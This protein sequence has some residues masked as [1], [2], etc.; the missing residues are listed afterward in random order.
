MLLIY[1]QGAHDRRP[2]AK[3]APSPPILGT[4]LAP[5][6][7]GRLWV[8]GKARRGTPGHVFS[9][10][11]AQ[12]RGRGLWPRGRGSHSLNRPARCLSRS[13]SPPLSLLSLSFHSQSCLSKASLTAGF[14][15][16]S[17]QSL[18]LRDTKPPADNAWGAISTAQ[19]PAKLQNTLSPQWTRES[20]VLTAGAET[21]GEGPHWSRLGMCVPQSTGDAA[22]EIAFWSSRPLPAHSRGPGA[23]PPADEEHT[24]PWRLFCGTLLCFPPRPNLRPRAEF[25]SGPPYLPEGPW[26]LEDRDAGQPRGA[27][28]SAVLETE[29]AK[30]WGPRA[31]SGCGNLS[32]RPITISRSPHGP[33]FP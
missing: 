7:L 20:Q 13:R 5:P 3:P 33:G 2:C 6:P 10:V 16:G 26:A 22:L 25:P 9:W 14:S 17:S 30:G 4:F 19:S 32:S 8:A 18:A 15:M 27:S 29:R 24:S 31:D 28:T 1:P 12:K 11:G 23:I 21:R